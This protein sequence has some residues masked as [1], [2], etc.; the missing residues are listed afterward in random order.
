MSSVFVFPTP[1]NHLSIQ[2]FALERLPLLPG[3]FF[4]NVAN[5][6]A[7]LS[8]L[9][10]AVFFTA[11]CGGTPDHHPEEAANNAG[12]QVSNAAYAAA[13]ASMSS[14]FTLNS[15]ENFN[16]FNPEE[17]NNQQSWVE[18]NCGNNKATPPQIMTWNP[19]T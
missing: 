9:V 15:T 2:S 17:W 14:S 10:L 4:A 12:Q 18:C 1:S 11:G 6:R 8:A 5:H 16:G 19:N 3:R 13:P 7:S